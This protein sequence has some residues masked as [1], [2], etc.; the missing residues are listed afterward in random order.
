MANYHPILLSWSSTEPP[1]SGLL[2]KISSA[3]ERTAS[4]QTQ[5]L[6]DYNIT[7]GNPIRE[8]IMYVE[9]VRDVLN[10]RDNYQLAYESSVEDLSRKRCEKD[11][12]MSLQQQQQQNSESANAT[13]T[14]HF[15]L[16]KAASS[17]QKLEKLGKKMFEFIRT[18]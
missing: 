18:F 15:S 3:I 1:L 14:S 16:W 13:S 12:L 4:A 2:I 8:F 5:L 6:N 7:L 10:K 17:D 9:V 11:Q